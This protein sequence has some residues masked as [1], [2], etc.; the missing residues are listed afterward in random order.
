MRERAWTKAN[1]WPTQYVH[2]QCVN[3]LKGV[4][5]K[6]QCFTTYLDD[7]PMQIEDLQTLLNEMEPD[8]VGTSCVAAMLTKL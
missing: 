1:E 2:K 8:V 6:T 5:A 3:L 4:S 7:F